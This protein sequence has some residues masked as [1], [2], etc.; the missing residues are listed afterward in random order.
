[1][2]NTAGNLLGT[3]PA[4]Q[5]SGTLSWAQLA[6][7]LPSSLLAGTYSNAVT[8]NN[9][10][11]SFTGHF[12]GNGSGLTN[13]N[14]DTLGG[15][16]ASHFWQLS[17]NA[18]TAASVNF[19]G[20][21][22]T[23]ALELK[24][25]G[26]R[27]LRLEP[28][29]NSPNVLGG[30]SGNQVAAG[31]LGATIGGGGSPQTGSNSIFASFGTVG[32]GGAAT[33]QRDSDFSTIG[34]GV[35]NVIQIN[36][37]YSTI[38]GGID[39][40]VISE[41]WYA[42]VGGGVG[43]TLS[44]WICATIGGGQQNAI[45]TNA[46][47]ATISGGAQNRILDGAC[48]STIG[49]GFANTVQGGDFARSATIGGGE[50]NT[51]AA[52]AATVG[53]GLDNSANGEE[54]TVPGGQWN[55]AA[56]WCSFAAGRRARAVHNGAFV[57]ADINDFD[58]TSTN[59]NSFSVRSVGGARF[60][61]S[62]DADG[63]PSAG[64]ELVSGGGSWSSLSDRNAKEHFAPVRPREVLERVN[65]MPITT[66]NYK[67][68]DALIRHIGPMAQDFAAAFQVGENDRHITTVD[69]DGVALAAI[70]GLNEVILEQKVELNRKEAEIQSLQKRLEILERA[71]LG[72]E[73][74]QNG[75]GQ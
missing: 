66:W 49:G 29:I 13:L 72:R 6:G 50:N 34:G 28:A 71:I 7:T 4:A 41:G 16:P 33:I 24:V 2:A 25:N 9:P 46:Q 36:A 67:S 15:L 26:Q 75:S 58:F 60:V 19:L 21:T 73:T 74:A 35:R 47:W 12:T 23:N 43:N 18:S 69:A 11:N 8:F 64:V 38:G 52:W 57:W 70:Q 40:Q 53:G 42:T 22:D 51:T 62:I 59:M 54:S 37:P 5:L 44:G 48:N 68:Q 45:L 63:I 27:A 3:L 55:T 39:N 14:T 61:S 1:M 65:R 30:W 10:A 17:G 31:V 32:G 56:G 20:T